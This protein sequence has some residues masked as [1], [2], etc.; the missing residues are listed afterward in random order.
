MEALME[1]SSRRT[2]ASAIAR[3]LVLQGDLADTP[4]PETVQF[5]QTLRKTGQLALERGNPPQA[6]GISFIDGNLVHAHCP[7][8]EGEDC[9]FYLLSWRTGR[10]LFV[11]GNP[12]PER[13]I[14]GDNNSLLLE[15]LRRLDELSRL[16]QA[17]PPAG[18]ILHRRREAA[19][20]QQQRFSFLILQ[21]WRR[22]D[23]RV[24][25]GQLLNADGD[26]QTARHLA[27]LVRAGLASPV[28]DYH[29]LEA[30]ILAPV[31]RPAPASLPSVDLGQRLLAVCDG[32]LS[33]AD[34]VSKLRCPPE[35]LIA[36]AEYLLALRLA[37]VVRGSAEAA[38][39]I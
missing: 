11:P 12:T 23:G 31:G 1:P 13:S 8:L 5:I 16:T 36:A 34:L 29:F 25:V 19:A 38:L 6:A 28:P 22:L 27:E 20:L 7:P 21:L 18:T 2:T 10:Y 30:I 14:K 15:G 39:L 24:T 17:L 26:P 4:L 3:G 32:R 9:F 35:D 37:R 33:L